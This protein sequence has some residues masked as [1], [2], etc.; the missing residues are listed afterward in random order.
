VLCFSK[1]FGLIFVRFSN[2]D[3]VHDMLRRHRGPN[4]ITIKR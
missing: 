2:V 3:Y 1:N 4:N